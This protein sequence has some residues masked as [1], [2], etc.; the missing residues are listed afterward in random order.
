MFS[1]LESRQFVGICVG[2]SAFATKHFAYRDT[3]SRLM[4][5]SPESAQP[6]KMS[7]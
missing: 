3:I 6:D 5:R 4:S 1:L 2:I 7:G